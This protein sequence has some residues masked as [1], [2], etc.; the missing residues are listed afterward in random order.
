MNSLVC[1]FLDNHP[2]HAAR[3]ASSF[4][5]VDF[6]E[7]SECYSDKIK[8]VIMATP[9]S[10]MA[11]VFDADA[12]KAIVLYCPLLEPVTIST[13]LRFSKKKT[14]SAVLNS[15]TEET[16]Q[17]VE[18]LLVYSSDQLG[19][20]VITPE[21][22]LLEHM[23]I[24]AALEAIDK[25]ND[26]KRPVYVLDNEYRL[27]GQLNVFKLIKNRFHS[28]MTVK[29]ITDSSIQSLKASISIKNVYSLRRWN[30]NQFFPVVG[31]GDTFLGMIC[32]SSLSITPE[33]EALLISTKGSLSEYIDFSEILWSGLNRFWGS[34]R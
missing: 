33:P 34:L 6:V 14:R 10:Y 12:E 21:I 11:Q 1:K 27:K 19:H 9:P 30:E 24:N 2:E 7:F 23:P 31:K 25:L 4:S 32:K 20:H 8:K 22:V 15:F 26:M 5:I 16:R 18:E 13:I 29:D 3:L 28:S 17:L